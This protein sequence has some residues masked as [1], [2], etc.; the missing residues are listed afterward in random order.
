ME[1]SERI[2]QEASLLFMKHGIRSVTMDD[3][4]KHMG[5]SKRT[6]Y[7]N[8]K[9]K[10]ELLKHCL[11][12]N[13]DQMKQHKME[14]VQTSANVIEAIF[15]IMYE[16]AGTMNQVNP[17]F[18]TDLR[19][20]H[21]LVWKEH[22]LKHQD[23]HMADL[24][25]LIYKGIE[26]GVFREDINVEIVSRMLNIQ[27]K[28][29]SNDEIFPPEEFTRAEVFMN[30][31]VNFTRGIATPEGIKTIETLIEQRKNELNKQ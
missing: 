6:I 18:I 24:K 26:D 13:K 4:A 31:I 19:K 2:I 20:Y 14:V 5:I 23:E 11:C 9:D 8:F 27:L 15:R 29:L 16:I 21:F 28:E 3:I 7:E 17:N 22:L 1:I 10:D 30:I 12:R 25:H